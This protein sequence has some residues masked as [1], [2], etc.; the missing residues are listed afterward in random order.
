MPLASTVLS[1]VLLGLISQSSQDKL[2]RYYEAAEAQRSAGNLTA[3]EN[4][5]ESILAEG[6]QRLAKICSARKGYREAVNAAEAAAT[7]RPESEEVLLDLGIA[8]FEAQEFKKALEPLHRILARNAESA[9]AH[10]MAGK[11]Y[12]MLRDAAKAA[13]E[14]EIALKLAPDNSDI[15]YT[16]GLAYLRER[17][18]APAQRVYGRM[19]N[20]L[21]DKPQ[22]HILFGRAYREAGFLVEAI[23][24]FK[25][26]LAFDPNYPRA[27]YYLGLT[28]LLNDG[29]SRRGEAKEEFKAELVAHPNEFFAHYYLGV[30]YIYDRDWKLAI[31]S[32]E[33][34]SQI[35]PD[36]P[37]P[38]FHLGQ[39][40]QGL[41]Q[42]DLAVEALRRTIALNPRLEHNEYQVTT[43]H[44]RLG[45]SLLKIGQTEAG[46]SELRLAS[47][48]KAEAFKRVKDF[49][50]VAGD[51][52]ETKTEL[53]PKTAAEDIIAKSSS[54]EEAVKFASES[55]EA[56]YQKVVASA[57]NNIGMLRAQ[58]QDFQGAVAQF[59]LA[60]KWNP[61]QEG[62]NYNLGLAYFKLE[63]FEEAVAPLERELK[64]HPGNSP[65]RQLLEL[66]NRMLK[67]KAGRRTNR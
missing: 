46:K 47:K 6:Y 23:E 54:P 8:Y 25:K 20:Q 44:Y 31:A 55:G 3:A 62:L 32:L 9:G 27:H 43:A 61:Q 51:T 57:H 65:A 11:T 36:S 41:D 29:A 58:Q 45:Q 5:F 35:Q 7:Y 38:Y 39:A 34:A 14:L 66:S 17:E 42:H 26:V 67:E 18:L 30:V 37:D 53:V 40:Y 13:T 63:M 50:S 21:G 2:R 10:H 15:A 12:F 4:E 28:Y 16:L 24:E 33:R 64:A 19:L 1:L 56:F 48:L 49:Y 59:S 22:I 60:A 52:G